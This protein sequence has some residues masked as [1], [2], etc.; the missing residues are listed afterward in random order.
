MTERF[1]PAVSEDYLAGYAKGA[2]DCRGIVDKM[3]ALKRERD[4]ASIEVAALRSQ[5]QGPG[6]TEWQPIASA[7]SGNVQVL[8]YEPA[9]RK[10][11]ARVVVARSRDGRSWWSE[12]GVYGLSPTHWQPLPAEPQR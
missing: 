9:C 6:P 11:A 4:Q 1:R 7:P 10:K 5:A 8:V 3:D 12:P 2:E